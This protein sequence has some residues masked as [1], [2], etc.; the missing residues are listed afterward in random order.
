M[1][2]TVK[3]SFRRSGFT[4]IELLVV[5]AIIGVLISLLLPAVQKVR[6]AANRTKCA[7]NMK[8]IGLTL[9]MYQDNYGVFPPGVVDPQE[10]PTGMPPHQ[11]YHPWWSWMAVTMAY[12]EQD[13]LY[14]EAD[15]WAHKPGFYYWPWGNPGNNPPP[16]PAL[17]TVVQLWICPADP[18]VSI[19]T[20]A[21]GGGSWTL[22]VAFTEYLGVAGLSGDSINGNY[23]DVTTRNGILYMKSRVRIGEISDGLSNT[24]MVGER[25]PSNDLWYGW[26]FAGAGW[27]DNLGQQ[28][29]GDVV[30]GARENRYWNFL[31]QRFKSPDCQSPVPLVGIWPGNLA[32]DCDYS[33]FWSLHSGGANFLVADGSVRF[34]LNSA[35]D[36]LLD[37][38][39][40]NGG[41]PTEL[42]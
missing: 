27:E 30:L 8:Q 37:L 40:R 7:N 20:D 35:N 6:D 15:D 36:I 25:P 26:W 24:L 1:E 12:Y 41:E 5:I 19:A 9:H 42:P 2:V 39:T 3:R 32:D 18:R 28:G 10:R 11:G 16:N 17:A 38:C 13:N 4:L 33:H 22:H 31:K 21:N 14:K 34:L 23:D 29:V